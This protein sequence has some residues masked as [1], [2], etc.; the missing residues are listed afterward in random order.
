MPWIPG[1]RLTPAQFAAVLRVFVGHSEDWYRTHTFHF[2][3]RGNVAPFVAEDAVDPPSL[4]EQ[5]EDDYAG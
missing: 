1:S 5:N 4:P 2:S 3:R